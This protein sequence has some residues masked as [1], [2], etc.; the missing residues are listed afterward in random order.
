V[1]SHPR[2]RRSIAAFVELLSRSDDDLWV[3][4]IA[5]QS[6][7]SQGD[8][9]GNE[10]LLNL[11]VDT[12]LPDDLRGDVVEALAFVRDTRTVPTLLRLIKDP[13]PQVRF[14]AIYA[15]GQGGGVEVLPALEEVVASDDGEM[16]PWGALRTEAQGSIVCIKQRAA[17]GEAYS[18]DT[19]AY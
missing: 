1:L 6:L 3:R 8:P 10:Y 9:R 14:W 2:S 11:A 5:A 13:S 16:P 18:T 15:L 4:K 12:S 17:L 19:T 7:G